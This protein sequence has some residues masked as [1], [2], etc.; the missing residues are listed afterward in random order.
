ME[1]IS[2]VR[3]PKAG[4]VDTA[5]VFMSATSFSTNAYR[6]SMIEAGDH[7]SWRTD[8]KNSV[9]SLFHLDLKNDFLNNDFIEIYTHSL[10]FA[11]RALH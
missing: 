10:G 7:A 2:G 1:I 4:D 3:L 5:L 6:M 8:H 9:E 11:P